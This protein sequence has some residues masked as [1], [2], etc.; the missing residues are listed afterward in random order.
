[1]L[2]NQDK[3]IN[4]VTTE[5]F[6]TLWQLTHAFSSG[7]VGFASLFVIEQVS[8]GHRAA[9]VMRDVRL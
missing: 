2:Y 6:L 3:R 9:R 8:S 4:F 5:K 7:G 1:M